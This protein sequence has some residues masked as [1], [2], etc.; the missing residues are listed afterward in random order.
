METQSENNEMSNNSPAKFPLCKGCGRSLSQKTGDCYYCKVPDPLLDKELGLLMLE[1]R[2]QSASNPDAGKSESTRKTISFL[3]AL[4]SAACVSTGILN[5][6]ASLPIYY[7]FLS[8][9]AIAF[10]C[11]SFYFNSQTLLFCIVTTLALLLFYTNVILKA[12]PHH[13]A[14]ALLSGVI[15]ALSVFVLLLI[16]LRIFKNK[17]F[18]L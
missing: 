8:A 6:I 2:Q 12:V 4:L 9:V 7:F 1:W 10:C 3:L 11:W 14:I 16:I 18:E 15:V 13:F 17:A 5:D